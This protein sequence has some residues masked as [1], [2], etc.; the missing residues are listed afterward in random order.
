MVLVTH[1]E[2][3]FKLMDSSINIVR[4]NFR[5]FSIIVLW[6]FL[7]FTDQNSSASLNPTTFL[8]N[9][10]L[11][12]DAAE[13]AGMRSMSDGSDD[14]EV[15]VIF[16]ALKESLFATM[17]EESWARMSEKTKKKMEHIYSGLKDVDPGLKSGVAFSPAHRAL[18][19]KIMLTS[20]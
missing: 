9:E 6:Q 3:H 20:R 5:M 10:L 12:A 15:A 16:H 13:S 7:C 17:R 18:L 4:E 14:H 8:E 11:A 19:R 1:P 2:R